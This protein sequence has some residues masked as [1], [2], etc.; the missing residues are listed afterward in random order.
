LL[1]ARLSSLERTE[2]K[3]AFR[4]IYRSGLGRESVL[5]ELD[6]CLSTAAGRLLYEFMAGG[7][8]RGVRRESIP[9]RRSA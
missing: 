2:I 6:K 3:S 8:K 5:D 7:S 4:I 9:L 1:R